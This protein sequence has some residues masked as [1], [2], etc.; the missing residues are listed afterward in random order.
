MK[1]EIQIKRFKWGHITEERDYVA[2]ENTIELLVNGEK[3]FTVS[4]S[5]EEL[6]PF[7]YGYLYTTG[8]ISTGKDIKKICIDKNKVDVRLSDKLSTSIS[9]SQSKRDVLITAF[10]NVV[11]PNYK[12]LPT[13]FKSFSR[14]S[15]IFDETGGVH[16]AAAICDKTSIMYFSEDIGRLSAVDKVIGKALL[17]NIDFKSG[18]YFLLISGRIS[19]EVIQKAGVTGIRSIVSL[20]APTA[21]AIDNANKYKIGIFGFWRGKT[22]NIYN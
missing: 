4:M 15:T 8:Y 20:S 17:D 21:T 2:E 5:P 9:P 1:K 22:F 18:E 11:S 12:K 6:K 7:A 13:L 16:S 10:D 14:Y 3:R 19:I